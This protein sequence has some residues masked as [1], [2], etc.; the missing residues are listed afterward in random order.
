VGGLMIMAAGLAMGT[1]AV[2]HY[3]FHVDTC[4][5]IPPNCPAP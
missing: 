5:W 2:M 3:V 4:P 1:L